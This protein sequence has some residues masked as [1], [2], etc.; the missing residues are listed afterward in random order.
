[1][2]YLHRLYNLSHIPHKLRQP[3]NSSLLGMFHILPF[4]FPIHMFDKK[5]GICS[6]MILHYNSHTNKFGKHQHYTQGNS[7]CIEHIHY[8]AW[9]NQ[10]YTI[11]IDIR[12]HLSQWYNLYKKIC[13]NDRHFLHNHSQILKHNIDKLSYLC[14]YY[15]NPY[16]ASIWIT[17]LSK[18][19]LDIKCILMNW[20]LS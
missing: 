9:N 20:F 8:W 2:Y 16:K 1:M 12:H 6:I 17:N 5:K 13:T 14:N 4:Y 7:T 3:L 11:C 19:L 18:Y 10:N 15:N